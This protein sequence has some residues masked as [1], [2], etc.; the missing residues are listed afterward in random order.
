MWL[1]I[2]I[3][4][5]IT[6]F[7]YGSK[8]GIKEFYTMFALKDFYYFFVD[9]TSVDSKINKYY[10]R[11]YKIFVKYN[12]VLHDNSY[13]LIPQLYRCNMAKEFL[14]KHPELAHGGGELAEIKDDI[15]YNRSFFRYADDQGFIHLF[16]KYAYNHVCK[17]MLDWREK[18]ELFDI[19]TENSEFQ[20]LSDRIAQDIYNPVEL[21]N[22][23]I[24][25]KNEY[26]KSKEYTY[27]SNKQDERIIYVWPL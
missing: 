24:T 22:R 5:V 21:L 8:I 2:I 3:M 27:R 1:I 17:H 18:N 6:I 15:E 23:I 10:D 19:P 7:T 14:S 16:R 11:N 25:I 9:D 13:I 4:I 12:G 20:M 26:V